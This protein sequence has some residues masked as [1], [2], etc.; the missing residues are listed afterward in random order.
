VRE[1]AALKIRASREARDEEEGC[2]VAAELQ[3]FLSL[4]KLVSLIFDVLAP[5]VDFR[6]PVDALVAGGGAS[7]LAK[8]HEQAPQAHRPI[9]SGIERPYPV[10]N[11]LY[12]DDPGFSATNKE[13]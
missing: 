10:T 6:S 8:A 11:D 9:P 3:L 1:G 5:L 2:R 7:R 4:K 13:E 12:R